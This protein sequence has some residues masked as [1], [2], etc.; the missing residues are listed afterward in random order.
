MAEIVL[1]EVPGDTGFAALLFSV[2][3]RNENFINNYQKTEHPNFAE[4]RGFA[5]AEIRVA[6]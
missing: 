2:V 1:G 6:A 5:A 3:I 4:T